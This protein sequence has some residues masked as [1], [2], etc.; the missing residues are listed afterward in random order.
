VGKWRRR[1]GITWSSR[2]AIGRAGRAGKY[3][4]KSPLLGDGLVVGC[5]CFRWPIPKGNSPALIIAV[6]SWAIGAGVGKSHRYCRKGSNWGFTSLVF[7]GLFLVTGRL[8]ASTR[9]SIGPLGGGLDLFGMVAL[10]GRGFASW[11]GWVI[12]W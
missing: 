2:E 5:C 11:L 6:G 1:F 7:V 8:R 10:A 4:Y 3:R 9:K 12:P